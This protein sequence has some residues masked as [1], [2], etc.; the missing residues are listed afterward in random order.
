M[1]ELVVVVIY[2]TE[3]MPR[4]FGN[5]IR[6]PG[7]TGIDNLP[8]PLTNNDIIL[9]INKYYWSQNLKLYSSTCAM[10]WSLPPLLQ[11]LPNIQLACQ[12]EHFNHISLYSIYYLLSGLALICLIVS[13]VISSLD[14]HK[15]S[16]WISQ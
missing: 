4:K 5:E 10:L 16:R 13:V 15:V 11:Q 7:T 1:I 9:N 2:W 14:Y 12:L 8:I 3:C 6:L